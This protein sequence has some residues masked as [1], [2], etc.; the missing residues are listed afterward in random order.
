MP[1]HKL[2]SIGSYDFV[3]ADKFVKNNWPIF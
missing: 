2:L 1:F 3:T